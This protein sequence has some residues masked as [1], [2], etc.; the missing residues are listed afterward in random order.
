MVSSNCANC[1]K[2][3]PAFC[4]QELRAVFVNICVVCLQNGIFHQP[5]KMLW[6]DA[7]L[8]LFSFSLFM[9]KRTCSIAMLACCSVFGNAKV[10][11]GTRRSS[12]SQGLSCFWWKDGPTSCWAAPLTRTISHWKRIKNKKKKNITVASSW[13]CFCK[14][15]WFHDVSCMVIKLQML[16][17]LLGYTSVLFS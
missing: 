14:Q 5:E 6:H 9:T 4:Y 2:L 1:N 13:I 16:V 10:W 11:R 12:F 17:N 7:Q 15:S 8:G 3:R